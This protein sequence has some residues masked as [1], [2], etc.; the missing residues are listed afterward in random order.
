MV[1]QSSCPGPNGRTEPIACSGTRTEARDQ[2]IPGGGACRPETPPSG[3]WQIVI[4][5]DPWSWSDHTLRV[6]TAL[7]TTGAVIALVVV[8]TAKGSV[9]TWRDHRKRPLLSLTHEPDVDIGREVTVGGPG[10][11]PGHR[12]TAY[13]RLGVEN[14]AGRRAAS[15]VEVTVKRVEQLEGDHDD[16]LPTYNM[17]PLGWTHRDPLLNKLGPGVRRTVVLGA[18]VA[19]GTRFHVGLDIAPPHT[20]VD[21]LGPGTYRFTLTVSGADVDARDWT[22]ELWHDGSLTATSK[23][24]DHVK[25]TAAPRRGRSG[26]G[27]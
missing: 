11:D 10:Q 4:C 3:P 2:R 15:A 24:R 7:G 19:S 9:R 12:T 27:L 16:R 21:L 26:V 18:L 13:V 25:I 20:G 1:I 6:L 8:E 23:V 17:G 22:V 5:L 14:A